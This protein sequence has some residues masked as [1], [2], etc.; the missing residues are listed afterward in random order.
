MIAH[1]EAE[2]GQDCVIMGTRQ[3]LAKIDTAIV[4][5]KLKEN[6]NYMGYYGIFNG[7]NMLEFRQV[8]RAGTTEFAIDPNF[9]LVC[10]TGN[11]AMVRLVL[12]GDSFIQDVENNQGDLSR[13]YLFIK[14]AGI[15]VVAANAYGIYRMT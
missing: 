8:H 3:A 14:K 6:R 15:L 10:P 9:L 12:E 13:E 2:T 1:I 4:S 7:V 5:E 11:Q